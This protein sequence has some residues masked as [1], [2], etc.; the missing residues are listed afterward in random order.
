MKTRINFNNCDFSLV[1]ERSEIKKLQSEIEQLKLS[2]S[3]F[4]IKRGSKVYELIITRD[5]SGNLI[6]NHQGK[7]LIGSISN[8]VAENNFK[9][10]MGESKEIIVK[11][12]MPGL[13]SKLNVKVGDSVKKGDG[14]LIIEAMKMENE[15][16]SPIKGIV[17]NIS[18]LPGQVVEKN[19]NLIIIK[20]D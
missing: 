7:I 5:E 14:L 3:Y 9:S 19:S 17:Q 4:I 12:P 2:S 1:F 16:K 6:I 18:V 15:I 20:S 13:I 8:I 11:S 10:S